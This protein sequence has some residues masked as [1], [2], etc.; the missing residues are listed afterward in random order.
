MKNLLPMAFVFVA[1]SILAPIP[2]AHAKNKCIACQNAC[3]A[4]IKRCEKRHHKQ[5]CF[6]TY[7]AEYGECKIACKGSPVCMGF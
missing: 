3:F 7:G 2:S 4:K 1:A 6:D 5:S